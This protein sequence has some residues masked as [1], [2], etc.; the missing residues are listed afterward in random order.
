M[1]IA[2]RSVY[3]VIRIVTRQKSRVLS[4]DGID[5]DGSSDSRL[6]RSSYMRKVWCLNPSRDKPKS[7]KQAVTAPLL[8]AQQQVCLPRVLGD[9]HYIRMSRV[10]VGVAR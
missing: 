9:D 10:T 6:E 1:L 8:N 7:L 3:R 4:H 5:I 2:G